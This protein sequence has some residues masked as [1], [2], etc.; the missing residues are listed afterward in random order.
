MDSPDNQQ[1][2]AKQP[3]QFHQYAESIWSVFWTSATAFRIFSASHSI[4]GRFCFGSGVPVCLLFPR[5]VFFPA[6]QTFEKLEMPTQQTKPPSDIRNL[7]AKPFSTQYI[8][9]SQS[10]AVYNSRK[11]PLRRWHETTTKKIYT[12]F[13]W[14]NRFRG[15]FVLHI[16][17]DIMV[18]R[19]LSVSRSFVP[20]DRH[21]T[22]IFHEQVKKKRTNGFCCVCSWND[23]AV[24]SGAVIAY[25]D[26]GCCTSFALF[27][28]TFFLATDKQVRIYKKKRIHSFGS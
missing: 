28:T 11:L 9:C 22:L 18:S 15:R 10:A 5:V 16:E 12:N 26:S 7:V 23:W 20:I 24:F 8:E 19:R 17:C 25:S 27:F 14:L 4:F 21:S 3:N 2:K 13:C 6:A 1:Q